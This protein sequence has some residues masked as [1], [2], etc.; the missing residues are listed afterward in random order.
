MLVEPG[1]RFT[2]L[3]IQAL[4]ATTALLQLTQKGNVAFH[5]DLPAVIECVA[6]CHRSKQPFCTRAPSICR[7]KFPSNS[8]ISFREYR[9]F[10]CL[11]ISNFGTARII[12]D[13]QRE[14]AAN[15]T[16]R[17]QRGQPHGRQEGQQQGQGAAEG[18][19]GGDGSCSSRMGRK[20]AR[21]TSR[22]SS[23]LEQQ[24]WGK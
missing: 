23:L 10:A 22:R 1:H 24:Q 18:A 14:V 21:A 9:N 17:Q 19:G 7:I 5:A 13:R 8:K 15:K 3:C 20:S 11:G 2:R 6:L 12:A 4:L 16:G